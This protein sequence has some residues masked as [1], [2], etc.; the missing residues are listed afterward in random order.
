MLRVYAESF[1]LTLG[2]GMPLD[3][4][5]IAWAATGRGGEPYRVAFEA[6]YHIEIGTIVEDM[7]EIDAM[8][9]VEGFSD[10]WTEV[11]LWLLDP[12]AACLTGCQQSQRPSL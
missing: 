5:L 4:Y 1:A 3:L 12:A 6:L 2:L 7:V 11:A 8:V 9:P 10:W